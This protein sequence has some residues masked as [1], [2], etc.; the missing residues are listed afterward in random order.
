[1]E[2]ARLQSALVPPTWLST[3]L[4]LQGRSSKDQGPFLPQRSSRGSS[5][6]QGIFQLAEELFPS[7]P[8]PG[9]FVPWDSLSPSA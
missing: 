5:G 1:M 2:R 9:A 3:A 8:S 4:F 7:R 6:V